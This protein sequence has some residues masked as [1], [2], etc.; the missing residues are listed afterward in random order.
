MVRS[1]NLLFLFSTLLVL[2]C[3]AQLSIDISSGSKKTKNYNVLAALNYEGAKA[4]EGAGEYGMVTDLNG[5]SCNKEPYQYNST[6]GP[7][8]EEKVLVLRGPLNL[9]KFRAFNGPSKSGGD[10]SLVSSYD[11]QEGKANNL[12]FLANRCP[13]YDGT[14]KSPMCYVKSDGLTGSKNPETFK[15]VLQDCVPGDNQCTCT[16]ELQPFGSEIY[17]Q[18]SKKCGTSKSGNNECMGCQ[19]EFAH[20]GWGGQKTL[21]HIKAQFTPGK[22]T[23]RPAIWFLNSQVVRCQQYGCNCR[24]MGSD[25]GCGELD[26][27]EVIE[28]EHDYLYSENYCTDNTKKACTNGFPKY[29][30]RSSKIIDY[31]VIFDA[32]KKLIKVLLLQDGSPFDT[33]G[34]T[35]SDEYVSQLAQL[36][37]S[38]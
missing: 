18:T 37:S 22:C 17:L 23:D 12:V 6:I 34:D 20:H 29:A 1:L 15:G 36:R 26:I 19:S 31:V 8:T 32:S 16:D 38:K 3:N 21:F 9:I 33:S 30:K 11:S 27:A 13:S 10:W 14:Q 25:G 24:M 35:L 28:N 7:W 4:G 5:K 2:F